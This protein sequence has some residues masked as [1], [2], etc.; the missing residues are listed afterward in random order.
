MRE[1]CLVAC[2]V[3]LG[4][5][6]GCGAAAWAERPESPVWNVVTF[7]AMAVIQATLATWFRRSLA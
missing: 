5:A 4:L 6:V 7:L 1:A 3:F 2:G